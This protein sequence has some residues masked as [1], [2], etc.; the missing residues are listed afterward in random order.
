[1]AGM[2]REWRSMV[3]LRIGGQCLDPPDGA[4]AEPGSLGHHPGLHPGS[5]EGAQRDVVSSVG[6]LHVLRWSLAALVHQGA[7]QPLGS[8]APLRAV[9]LTAVGQDPVDW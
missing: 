9:R 6:L 8:L 1:M 7:A 4:L 5:F 2:R 3:T